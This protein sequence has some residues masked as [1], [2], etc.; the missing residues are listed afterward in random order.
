M[1]CDSFTI[2]RT[3]GKAFFLQILSVQIDLLFYLLFNIIQ[4]FQT[5]LRDIENNYR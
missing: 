3:K 1:L 4:N 2:K 5:V